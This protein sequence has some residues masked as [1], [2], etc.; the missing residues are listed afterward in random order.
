MTNDRSTPQ[1]L[2]LDDASGTHG[3]GCG[4]CGCGAATDSTT[5]GSPLSVSASTQTFEVTGMTCGH[6]TSAVT[7]E[8][9]ALDGVN[10]VRVDL[11]PDGTSQVTVDDDSHLSREQVSAALEEA[12]GYRLV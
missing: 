3:C 1:T 5:E 11:V 7:T 8:L 6:C 12:G 10:D 4:G 2:Q 9:M